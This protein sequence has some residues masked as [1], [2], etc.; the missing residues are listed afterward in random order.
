MALP[1]HWIPHRRSDG[2]VIGWIDLESAGPA[3]QPIDRL[4]RPLSPV[5]DWNDAE[6][7]LEAIGL[8]FLTHRFA[9]RDQVVRIRQVYDDRVIVTTALTDAVGDVGDEFTLAFPVGDELV[10]S[11]EP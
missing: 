11:P 4:G 10:E 1:E 9:Y 7:A 2:E 5:N 6:E 3:V 8:G